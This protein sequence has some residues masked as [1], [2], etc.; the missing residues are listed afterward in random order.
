[1][2]IRVIKTGRCDEQLANQIIKA[3]R[4][5][6]KEMQWLID[7]I[8]ENGITET[9]S[10]ATERPVPDFQGQ[11]NPVGQPMTDDQI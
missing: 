6:I 5:E 3:Q 9:Q 8:A 7:D 10:E 2:K 11:L 1:M 4:K